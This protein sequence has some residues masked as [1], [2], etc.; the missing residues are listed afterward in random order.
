MTELMGPDES[1]AWLRSCADRHAE[2][3]YP[4]QRSVVAEL[5]QDAGRTD[6]A[7]DWLRHA[8][9]TGD[10]YAWS[11]YAKVLE[12]AGRTAEAQQMRRHGWE[13]DGEISTPWSAA[14]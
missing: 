4:D 11:Q 6:E 5:L 12:S 13:P 7:L 8:S 3:G 10:P 14:P 1:F 9:R 2:D